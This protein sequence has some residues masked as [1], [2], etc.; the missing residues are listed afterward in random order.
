MNCPNCG[1]E[2]LS[3]QKFC[4]KC[5]ATLQPTAQPLVEPAAV[6]TPERTQAIVG[7]GVMS[8]VGMTVRTGFIMMVAGVA[9]GVTGKKMFQMD[10]VTVIG[11]LLAIAGIFIVAY[12]YLPQRRRREIVQTA[13][14]E[15]LT[16]A[17]PTKK[18]PQMSDI[19]FVP[20][21]VTEGTT[22]LLKTPTANCREN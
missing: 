8:L 9:L 3:D 18:L 11:A 14:P 12:P 10:F 22:D 21:S 1:L 20:T 17:E 16:R 7:M 15:A 4:R 6:T 19:D 5:G 13:Q 2:P